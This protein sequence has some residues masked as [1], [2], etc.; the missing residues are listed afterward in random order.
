MGR[1]D[2][3]VKWS[4]N[5]TKKSIPELQKGLIEI[6]KKTAGQN[7]EDKPPS[8]VS[9]RKDSVALGTCTLEAK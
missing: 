6:I 8:K 9:Q 3:R 2:C 5:S 1:A 7:V 4:E